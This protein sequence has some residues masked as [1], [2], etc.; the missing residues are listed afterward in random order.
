MANNSR[1]PALAPLSSREVN[2][3]EVKSGKDGDHVVTDHGGDVVVTQEGRLSLTDPPHAAVTEGAGR[4]RRVD[5]C[6]A[7]GPVSRH[8]FNSPPRAAT[9]LEEPG[10]GK[11]PGGESHEVP[12]VQGPRLGL[13]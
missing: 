4:G 10:T 13:R 8:H 2:E 1:A 11:V 7:R 6:G 3:Y 5:T 12:S 9:G